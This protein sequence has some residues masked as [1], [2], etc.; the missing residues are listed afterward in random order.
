MKFKYIGNQ[1]LGCIDFVMAGL[2]RP[3][4]TLEPDKVYDVPD[5]DNMFISMCK[6]S[7]LFELAETKKKTKGD[8]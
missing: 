1:P 6:N 5:D 8:K 3:G 7:P 2:I 4:G